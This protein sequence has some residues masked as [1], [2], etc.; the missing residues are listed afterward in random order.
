MSHMEE[1]RARWKALL[2]NY[3]TSGERVEAW[4]KRHQ[5]TERQFYYWRRKLRQVDEPLLPTVKSQWVSLRLDEPVASPEHTLLVKVGA[6]TIE[7]RPG[8]EPSL[9]AEVVRTL[10]LL[11]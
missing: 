4:C 1:R 3:K 6:A 5:V 9:L 7:V 11:C 10:Q 8:F 2:D